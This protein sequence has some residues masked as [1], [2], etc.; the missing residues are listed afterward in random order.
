[1]HLVLVVIAV[2]TL[3]AYIAGGLEVA[4]GGRRLAS[5]NQASAL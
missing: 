2:L 5:D 3:L 1:M 4:L